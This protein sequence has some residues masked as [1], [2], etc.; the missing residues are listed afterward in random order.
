M[1]KSTRGRRRLNRFNLNSSRPTPNPI[2]P[3]HFKRLAD[4]SPSPGGEG[5]GEGERKTISIRLVREM[6]DCIGHTFIL[7][8]LNQK[9]SARSH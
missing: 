8:A 4:D 9:Q 3:W 1:G 5:R 2:L 7:N 6:R